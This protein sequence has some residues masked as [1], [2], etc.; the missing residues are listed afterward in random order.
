MARSSRRFRRR[1]HSCRQQSDTDARRTSRI[2]TVK[3]RLSESG[4][5]TAA[6]WSRSSPTR[7][8][9][10][11]RR[12]VLRTAP[13]LVYLANTHRR[14]ESRNPLFRRRRSRSRRKRRLWVRSCL[15]GVKHLADDEIVLA[16][17]KDSPLPRKIGE[18]VTMTFFPPTHQGEPR[19]ERA[20]FRLAGF[21]PLKG[22]AGDPD[23][24]PEFPGITD[25]LSITDWDPPFPYDNKRVKPR[26]ENYWQRLPHHAE[27][28]RQS[29][30][31]S[32]SVGQPLRSAHLAALGDRERQT[33]FP[34][35]PRRSRSVCSIG[36]IPR[37]AV[38]CSILSRSRRYKPATSGM[39]F[40]R[41]V[42]VLQ[43]LL[44]RGIAA[45]GGFAIPSEH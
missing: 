28:L 39:N 42:L 44:D 11:R 18:K 6:C 19:E 22:V 26:D 32:A 20:M 29:I 43:L 16:D 13:T 31:R 45:V 35:R 41:V 21:V 37:R 4:K 8:W 24:T 7:R 12:A 23:L 15:H 30:G 17:W 2:S 5:Q 25:K 14:R 27:S 1:V 38:S 10:R 40:A 36:S 9:R 34:K 3:S 33:I